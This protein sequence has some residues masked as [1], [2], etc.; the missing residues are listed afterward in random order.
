MILLKS[1]QPTRGMKVLRRQLLQTVG[2]L[3]FYC[4]ASDYKFTDRREAEKV[5][6]MRSLKLGWVWWVGSVTI[7]PGLFW[8][9]GCNFERDPWTM[10][11]AVL[12]LASMAFGAIAF[13]D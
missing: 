2:G 5:S 9:G 4:V 8:I 6:I 12:V 1:G 10:T 11:C 7:I 3:A 13:A